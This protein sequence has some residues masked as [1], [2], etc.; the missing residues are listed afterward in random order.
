MGK[1]RV[2]L[3]YG[4]EVSLIWRKVGNILAVKNNTSAIRGFKTAQNPER[5]GFSAATGAKQSEKFIF[6]Y[7]KIQFIQNDLLSKAFGDVS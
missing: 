5:C 6:P 7:G 2:F 1:Q 3:K 4:V